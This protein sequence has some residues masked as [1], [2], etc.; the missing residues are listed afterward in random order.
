MSPVGLTEIQEGCRVN[1]A[2][3]EILLT[4]PG[5]AHTT[6]KFALNE[7]MGWSI[8][9]ALLFTKDQRKG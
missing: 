5:P 3:F 4:Q 1:N 7:Y 2:P 8:P 9:P 6:I